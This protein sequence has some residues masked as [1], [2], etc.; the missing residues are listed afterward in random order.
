[1]RSVKFAWKRLGKRGKSFEG[2]ESRRHR[3]SNFLAPETG[4]VL[5]LTHAF[6]SL[7][8]LL[9]YVS[10]TAGG[11]RESLYKKVDHTFP[12]KPPAL[13][14]GFFVAAPASGP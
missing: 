8:F 13:P 3:R 4:V 6:D 2:M 10:K 11:G 12:K 14:G 9:F 7:F 5:G 1:M